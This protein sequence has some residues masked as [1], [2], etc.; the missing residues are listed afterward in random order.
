MSHEHLGHVR[1]KY[2]HVARCTDDDAAFVIE[3]CDGRLKTKT[4]KLYIIALHFCSLSH[5]RRFG[6]ISKM[7]KSF[8][9]FTNFAA[10]FLVE[11]VTLI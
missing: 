9:A 3:V 2:L 6:Y 4:Q 7:R 5:L 1:M 8:P 11:D 10:F